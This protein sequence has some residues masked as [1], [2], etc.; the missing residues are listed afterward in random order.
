M[1]PLGRKAVMQ[2]RGGEHLLTLRLFKPLYP[3]LYCGAIA[4][5]CRHGKVK[6]NMDIREGVS[7]LHCMSDA[8]LSQELREEFANL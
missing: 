1:A 3:Y 8:Y 2:I 4:H 5:R 7:D 6:R